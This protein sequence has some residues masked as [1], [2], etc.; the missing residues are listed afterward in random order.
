MRTTMQTDQLADERS[1]GAPAH[2]EIP[3]TGPNDSFIGR[4]LRLGR[5]RS[6]KA[7][8]ETATKETIPARR[9]SDPGPEVAR[10]SMEAG[11]SRGASLLFVGRG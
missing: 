3:G 9:R 1:A 2:Q 7:V 11:L 6:S 5:L 8:A 4:L 10:A